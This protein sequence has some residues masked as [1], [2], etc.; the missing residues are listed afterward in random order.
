MSEALLNFLDQNSLE[1][2]PAPA[3]QPLMVSET[4]PQP[5]LIPATSSLPN[6]HGIAPSKPSTF[7]PTLMPPPAV[8][9]AL[10]AEDYGPIP[11]EPA[12]MLIIHPFI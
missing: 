11:I 4:P 7:E 9:S 10:A 8:V 5:K 1:T 6:D 12:G 3:S 2:A